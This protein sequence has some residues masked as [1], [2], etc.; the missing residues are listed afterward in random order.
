MFQQKIDDELQLV[1]LH[2]ALAQELYD[3]VDINRDYLSKWLIFPPL[4]KS[5][6]DIKTFIKKSVTEFADEKA[7]VCGIQK[8]GKLVGVIG[9]NKIL[10]SLLKVEIGYWLSE[11]HQGKGIMFRACQ[12]MIEYAFEQLGL[13][14]IEIRAASENKASRSVCERLGLTL[15]GT[16]TNCENL[17]GKIVDH[18]VY[19]IHA[20]QNN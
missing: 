5:I 15:E 1:F 6:D 19:G 4:I 12:S 11:E 3:L 18:A 20:N 8:D 7:M 10:K 14:K 16:I 2:P 13:E 17:H 9:F